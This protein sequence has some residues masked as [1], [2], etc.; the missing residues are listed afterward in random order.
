LFVLKRVRRTAWSNINKLSAAFVR[1]K[2]VLAGLVRGPAEP[3]FAAA[4]AYYPG[5][6][7]PTSSLETDTLILIGDAYDW[8]PAE[9]CA[10]W[11]DTVPTNGRTLRTKT[12]PGARHGFDA[13]SFCGP[14][15]RARPGGDGGALAETRAFFSE[16]LA[17]KSSP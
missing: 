15:R 9:R 11:R 8:T 5:C 16:R 14:L 3:A 6:D 12:Y 13:P 17:L 10:R 2:A 4:V 7:P 1:L